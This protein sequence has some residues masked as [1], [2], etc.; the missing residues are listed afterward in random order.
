MAASGM[1]TIAQLP[2][3]RRQIRRI[4]NQSKRVTYEDTDAF[5][6]HSGKRVGEFLCFGNAKSGNKLVLAR[7][8]LDFP[9]TDMTRTR[10]SWYEFFA[11]GGMARIGLGNLW[12]CTFANEWCE[13]KAAAYR[14]YFGTSSELSVRDVGLLTTEDLPG[15]VDLAWASFP[16]QDLSLAGSGAGLRGKRS[17]TFV[18][19]WKLVQG[20][21]LEGR[22]PRII[23]LENVVGTITSHKGRDFTSLLK[24]LCDSGYLVG[25]LV[26]DAA[27]FVPQSRPRLFIVAVARGEAIP[28]SLIAS[29]S[30]SVWHSPSLAKFYRTLDPSLKENWIWWS[31][32][33]PD[34]S[35]PPLSSVIDDEPVG[36]RWHSEE[37]TRRLISMM[38]NLNRKKLALAQLEGVRKIGT[39][40]R[41]TRPIGKGSRERRQ[42]RA[43]IRFDEVSGCL[44]TP[45]GGSSRQTILVVEGR[46]VRS[47]LLSPAEAAR[48]MGVPVDYP[49]PG[50]YNDAYHLF[51]DGLVV[52]VVQWLEK[53]LLRPLAVNRRIERVA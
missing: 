43:E 11:G 38:S 51:G 9:I 52:P 23:V 33:E 27:H 16:C 25:P 1:G 39:L 35:V 22:K 18:S 28:T 41:R 40:Y 34:A 8:F 49:I 48:L 20:L 15:M 44:R 2:P 32:P 3:C 12:R 13:R 46:K 42:Q 6:E 53:F 50:R 10:L 5:R 21:I 4:G 31:L 29:P 7:D 24:T 19:F 47:R 37:E 36:V 14:A 17:G 26:V 30:K 45:V